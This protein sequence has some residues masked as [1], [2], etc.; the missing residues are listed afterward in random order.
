M[1][2]DVS[3][4]KL[5][6]TQ[7]R[8]SAGP[9]LLVFCLFWLLRCPA[10]LA[11]V[12][13]VPWGADLWCSGEVRVA[14]CAHRTSC[15]ASL[16]WRAVHLQAPQLTALEAALVHD[17]TRPPWVRAIA[18]WFAFWREETGGE[19]KFRGWWWSSTNCL[20]TAVVTELTTDLL[21]F[22]ILLL[23]PYRDTSLVRKTRF[24]GYIST[25][26]CLAFS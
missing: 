24:V 19:G 23:L 12:R 11:F 20:G 8:F 13:L 7:E 14:L 2:R 22:T 5:S 6:P 18:C 21:Q 4:I 10:L 26:A 25:E 17:A 15:F 16:G 1:D 9:H 3:G